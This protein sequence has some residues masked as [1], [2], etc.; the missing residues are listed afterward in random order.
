MAGSTRYFLQLKQTLE[1]LGASALT[2]GALLFVFILLWLGPAQAEP[3]KLAE[4]PPGSSVILS[5]SEYDFP[6]F[7]I[8]TEDNQADGFSVE[9][10][11]AALKAMGREV[12]FR[13]GPWS[14]VKEFLSQ[15]RVQV[16]PLVGRTPEREE[17]FDF[18]VPYITLH[19][20]LVVRETTT[21]ILSPDDLAGRQVAVMR[22]D[23]AEE[24]LR[25][26]DLDDTRIVTTAT[27]EDALRELAEGRHDAVVV[28]KL[29][30]QQLIAK[31]GLSNLRIVGPPLDEFSQAFC[32]AVRAGDKELLGIL[33][34]GLSIVMAD[35][36][37]QRLRNKWLGPIENL[38]KERRRIV[39][40]GDSDY[41]PFEFLDE[42]GEPAGFNVD[43]TRAIARQLGLDISIRLGPWKEIRQ[44]LERREIDV[45]QGMF[46]S[47][48]REDVFDFTPAHSIVNHAIV[49]RA[50]ARMPGG[51]KEL[52]GLSIL[53]M[54]GDIM[55]DA[56][57]DLGLAEQIFP[58][59]SQKEALRLLAEGNHDVALVAKLPALYWVE[60]YGWGNL[61]LSDHS[62]RS[63]EYCYAVPRHNEW[64]LAHF[65][66]GLANLRATGEFREIYAAWLGGY[67]KPEIV[68]LDVLKVFLWIVIPILLLLVGA[69]LWSRAL[70]KIVRKQTE[71]LRIEIA[72]RRQ[73][74]EDLQATNQRLET[75]MEHAANLA[76]Q[77]ERANLAKSEFLATISHEIRT[78]MNGV[79]GMAG[80]L[81]DSRLDEEQRYY[82]QGVRSSAESLMVLI[83]SIL[84]FSKIEAGK[85]DLEILDFDL[86][87]F[88]EDFNAL[89][90][91]HARNKDLEFSCEAAADV[92]HL[93]QGDPGRLRQILTNLVDNAIKF[94]PQGRVAVQVVVQEELQSEVI[95]K[96]SVRDTGI[97]IAK[98]GQ[99]KLFQAF[100]QLDAST[101]RKFGGSGLGL[102]ICKQLA[103]MMGGSIGVES[104]DDGEGSLF[105]FTARL[106]L[107]SLAD[108]P[109]MLPRT[110][111]LDAAGGPS[112]PD[113]PQPNTTFFCNARILLAEDN[114]VNQLVA[115]RLLEKMGLRVDAVADGAEAVRALE[116]RPYDLV[117]MDVSMPEVDGYEA[118]RRIRQAQSAV[119][120]PDIPVVAMTAHV[121]EADRLRCLEV[122]MNDYLSKPIDTQS[123][124]QMLKKWLPAQSGPD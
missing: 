84:D 68:F 112:P 38:L 29:V 15:G 70:R 34:E 24:F 108:V 20:T 97:G 66:E 5:A 55:H 79:I 71:E 7:C 48:E 61:Q 102:A 19:G 26:I 101:T 116:E 82:A 67:E 28:Q 110:A 118:T 44:A 65:S 76:R 73:A 52:D 36:T 85:L 111:D 77:A 96:F 54:E 91:L 124:K 59:L 53:V 98:E 105:W 93:L 37:F 6:P 60:K 50:G 47:L 13:I 94:T 89:M 64:L 95:L 88:L 120:N 10:L 17:I 100:S 32:F 109:E 81:L 115:V 25:R 63:P 123:L 90:A 69:L 21:D 41:P 14:E 119:R 33:N 4:T 43:L 23:N 74:A 42:N 103:E 113:T 107:Q 99:E 51:L 3:T 86:R 72:E 83:N 39:V 18:T 12:S 1:L 58:V 87:E 57:L 62:V 121:M 75:A 80:L 16:L 104:N 106:S 78:P 45:V 122:G 114:S 56:A 30:A 46:Y 31:Q 40:G 8:V 2:Q 22:G 27:F 117:F 11:R 9:L 35:G 49:V 92:P